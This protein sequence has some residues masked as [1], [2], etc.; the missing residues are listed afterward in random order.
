[1]Q[2]NQ[3]PMCGAGVTP[4]A[5][6]CDYCESTF[7][8]I[9]VDMS[10]ATSKVS[11][12]SFEKWR[13]ILKEDPNSAEANYALGL[14]Y[15]N[16]NLNEQAVTH[17]RNACKLA[18]ETPDIHYNL[19]L[20]LFDNGKLSSS[21]ELNEM[22]KEIEV[23]LKIDP[24]FAEAK[25]FKHF[26][27]GIMLESSD[28]SGAIKQYQSA[29]STC[30]D[31]PTFY[32]NLGA[33]F[34]NKNDWPKAEEYFDK[35]YELN[36]NYHTLLYNIARLYMD[37]MDK[38]TSAGNTML[39]KKNIPTALEVGKRGH[40]KLQLLLKSD[41]IIQK[42][43]GDLTTDIKATSWNAGNVKDPVGHFYLCYARVNH[44]TKNIEDAKKYIAI[45]LDRD[46]ENSIYKMAKKQIEGKFC[47]V[48]TAVMN[49]ADHIYVNTLRSFRDE[50]LSK[51]TIGSLFIEWYWN[52]GPGMADFVIKH[53]ALRLL[54]KNIIISPLAILLGWLGFSKSEHK[55]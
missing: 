19:A 2:V 22:Q 7:I 38:L 11:Q 43:G 49:D 6:S 31:I 23:T 12:D 48:A 45:A 37:W 30:S 27:A 32:N 21:A 25:A 10:H 5:R 54:C 4:R 46:P 24:T 36:P 20:A 50:C 44:W 55:K 29:I 17:L 47:F 14:L 33:L 16:R 41:S 13:K 51:S 42:S 35:A 52:N 8:N 39:G 3:C 15:Q 28:Q 1:M 40:K 53:N 9:G 34:L 26:F 18:P